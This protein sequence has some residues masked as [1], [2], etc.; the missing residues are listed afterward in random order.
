MD[1]WKK[2]FGMH[3]SQDERQFAYATGCTY[4]GRAINVEQGK[5]LATQAIEK[6][7][8]RY[9]GRWSSSNSPD[10]SFYTDDSSNE[11]GVKIRITYAVREGEDCTVICGEFQAICKRIGL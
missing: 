3:S 5:T 1:F 10:V 6:I 11:I 2:L 8:S 9:P 7:Y 4:L